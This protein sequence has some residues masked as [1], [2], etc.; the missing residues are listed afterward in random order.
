[1]R[2][3]FRLLV[4]LLL[5]ACTA[6]SSSKEVD[7]TLDGAL[8]V[9][10]TPP[11]D[12]EVLSWGLTVEAATAPAGEYFI[13]E[14]DERPTSDAALAAFDPSPCEQVR[15]C[16]GNRCEPSAQSCTLNGLGTFSAMVSLESEGKLRLRSQLEWTSQR[17]F[18]AVVRRGSET[19]TSAQL[20]LNVGMSQNN[21]GFCGSPD[22]PGVAVSALSSPDS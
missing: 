2:L 5:S 15:N 13:F 8:V 1:M 14:S 6:P 20:K 9:E 7:A 22:P 3:R 16:F 18:Y 10:S 21:G 19:A 17:H 11:D 12:V 4:P